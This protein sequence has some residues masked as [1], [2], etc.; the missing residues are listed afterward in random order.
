MSVLQVS[1]VS[2]SGF[3]KPLVDNLSFSVGEGEIV[4]LVGPNGA[5]KTTTLGLILGLIRPDSGKIVICGHDMN[6][7]RVRALRHVGAVLDNAAMY[8]YLTGRENLNHFARLA[9]I[10]EREMRISEA[11]ALVGL[12]DC[13]HNKVGTYSLGMLQR[14]SIAQA[15]IRK[16]K[17]LVLDEPTNGLDLLHIRFLR[18]L[19][20]QLS[21]SGSGILMSSHLL[22]EV[23]YT[24]DRIVMI[25]SGKLIRE[26]TIHEL[27]HFENKPFIAIGVSNPRNAI[28]ILQC[29]GWGF[30]MVSDQE[31]QGQIESSTVPLIIRHLVFSN[32]D[33]FSAKIIPRSLEDLLEESYF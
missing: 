12:Q 16:P 15:L 19:L 8:P 10:L 18:S 17:L 29:K 14:L 28:E 25:K 9:N 13:I 11:V 20:K 1:H 22:H 21:A 27:Q 32:I 23:E 5:G 7:D 4:A 6:R 33:V 30:H 3:N 31:I 2:R 26:S 24:C